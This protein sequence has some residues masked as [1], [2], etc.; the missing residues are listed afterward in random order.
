MP[1]VLDKIATLVSDVMALLLRWS[2]VVLLQSASAVMSAG[3]GELTQARAH[4]R[5]RAANSRRIFESGGSRCFARG[6]GPE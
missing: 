3:H 4:A 6:D 1:P 5:D 2:W